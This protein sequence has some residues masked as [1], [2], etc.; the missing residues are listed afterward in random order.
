MKKVF[1]IVIS[2]IVGVWILHHSFSYLGFKKYNKDSI[3]GEGR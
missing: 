2:I 1:A 3:W